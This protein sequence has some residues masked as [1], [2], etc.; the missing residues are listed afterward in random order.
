MVRSLSGNSGVDVVQEAGGDVEEPVTAGSGYLARAEIWPGA[1]LV[2]VT[3]PGSD[4]GIILLPPDGDIPVA[5]RLG[6]QNAQE[7]HARIRT[8]RVS[9]HNDEVL[10]VDEAPPMFS[11]ADPDGNG[12]VNLQDAPES[13]TS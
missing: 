10:Q 11:F 9:L 13:T 2:E 1:R 4:V 8:A 12:L 7:A 6:T 5:V 3:P